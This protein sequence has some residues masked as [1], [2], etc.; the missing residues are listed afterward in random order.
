M[1]R[2]RLQLSLCSSLND[3]EVSLA[4]FAQHSHHLACKRVI[5]IGKK[6]FTVKPL[7]ERKL[8]FI[9]ID[10]GITFEFAEEAE[11]KRA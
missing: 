4:M 7:C 11:E 2:I 3:A 9:K 1:K 8:V 5:I 10:P 6:L